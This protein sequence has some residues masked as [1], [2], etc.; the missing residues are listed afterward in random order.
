MD[1]IDDRVP[2]KIGTMPCLVWIHGTD[3]KRMAPGLWIRVKEER[4]GRWT[5]VLIDRIDDEGHVFASR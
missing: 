3:R 2:M 1:R 5:Q 4:G